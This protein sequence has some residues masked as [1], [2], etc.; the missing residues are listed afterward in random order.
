MPTRVFHVPPL[1][2]AAA[3]G[4]LPQ[5]QAQEYE[6]DYTGSID[7]GIGDF[8]IEVSLGGTRLGF[9]FPEDGVKKIQVKQGKHGDEGATITL[10]S[11][12]PFFIPE[13]AVVRVLKGEEAI[14][15]GEVRDVSGSISTG[16]DFKVTVDGGYRLLESDNFGDFA[17]RPLALSQVGVSR[18]AL[19][20]KL[21]YNAS[22]GVGFN[23]SST[24]SENNRFEI[25][26][27][28]EGSLYLPFQGLQ[29]SEP[30]NN[31]NF[32]RILGRWFSNSVSQVVSNRRPICIFNSREE[33]EWMSYCVYSSS[34]T[35]PTTDTYEI[36]YEDFGLAY[37]Y[38]QTSPVVLNPTS[39]QQLLIDLFSPDENDSD[40]LASWVRV[41]RFPAPLPKLGR[42]VVNRTNATISSNSII[43]VFGTRDGRA[44]AYTGKARSTGAILGLYDSSNSILD[45]RVLHPSGDDLSV[46]HEFEIEDTPDQ[47]A[48][49]EIVEQDLETFLNAV[50]SSSEYDYSGIDIDVVSGTGVHPSV[51][52]DATF[53]N[54]LQQFLNSAVA[55]LADGFW[56]VDAENR[57]YF[58]QIGQGSLEEVSI[59]EQENFKEVEA[60]YDNSRIVNCF[61]GDVSS[62]INDV[63]R[64]RFGEKCIVIDRNKFLLDNETLDF[65]KYSFPIP[66]F[67]LETWGVYRENVARVN[68][69]S[70]PA[71]AEPTCPASVYAFSLPLGSVFS[72]RG[73]Q[74]FDGATDDESSLSGGKLW[75]YFANFSTSFQNPVEK[76]RS[77]L[78]HSS[79][80]SRLFVRAD[81]YE[82]M[83]V[84]PVTSLVELDGLSHQEIVDNFDDLGSGEEMEQVQGGYVYEPT[85]DYFFYGFLV[86]VVYDAQARE[87]KFY[88]G[89]VRFRG[90]QRISGDVKTVVTTVSQDGVSQNFKCGVV[91]DSLGSI[92]SGG[93]NEDANIQ[94]KLNR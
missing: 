93:Y 92:V 44:F 75:F 86:R 57:I 37:V 25:V 66:T 46:W 26:Q 7:A 17:G 9:I 64:L 21:G 83:R 34:V 2:G 38:G 49:T 94:E 15:R 16:G 55:F 78:Y 12:P 67:S 35:V 58:E 20:S 3:L 81:E 6:I 62:G 28:S 10:V 32:A 22:G 4:R 76:T 39:N 69:L 8:K 71:F 51:F 68:F 65:D 40:V 13:G 1:L 48:L 77:S 36:A 11:E 5:V 33:G 42:V 73:L 45:S 61:F 60:S 91:T 82:A 54:S 31:T 23:V 29:A 59:L 85:G 74:E 50:I 18:S 88:G 14:F 43:D 90:S 56:G 19:S 84:I 41:V 53:P 24:R 27:S 80:V 89:S 79:Q 70:A 52:L 47:Y 63:P 87:R 72:T 30:A